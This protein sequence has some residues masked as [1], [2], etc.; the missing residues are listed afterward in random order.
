M[1]AL[2]TCATKFSRLSLVKV[3][4]TASPLLTDESTEVLG[5]KLR[6]LRL[7]SYLYVAYL[8]I[9]DAAAASLL[10][11]YEAD[12]TATAEALRFGLRE[13]VHPW[14][15]AERGIRTGAAARGRA[16]RRQP[17]DRVTPSNCCRAAAEDPDSSR[18]LIAEVELTPH[19]RSPAIRDTKDP[20]GGTCVACW[21]TS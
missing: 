12:D 9:S 13:R 7:R 2:F 19:P 20:D 3:S 15:S 16:I 14:S 5:I 10:N 4:W 11:L 21:G 18:K 6:D 8:N 17:R 1:R